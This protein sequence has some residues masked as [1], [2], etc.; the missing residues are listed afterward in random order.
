[1]PTL[2][3]SYIFNPEI[4]TFKS[5]LLAIP[6]WL[7]TVIIRES[8]LCGKRYTQ[9]LYANSL[10]YFNNV[11]ISLL[12]LSLFTAFLYLSISFFLLRYGFAIYLRLALNSWC[13]LGCLE[14]V[15][16]L[17]PSLLSAESRLYAIMPCP[18]IDSYIKEKNTDSLFFWF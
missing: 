10:L 12:Y 3:L 1:M 7:L 5:Y 11:I 8:F 16:I 4:S 6:L 2:L 17:L 13:S 15:A 18:G 14:V 9:R